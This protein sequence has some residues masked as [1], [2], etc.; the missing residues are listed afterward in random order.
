MMSRD[1]MASNNATVTTPSRPKSSAPSVSPSVRSKTPTARKTNAGGTSTLR[2]PHGGSGASRP[3]SS[4]STTSDA[5]TTF[6]S[7][8]SEVRLSVAGG[9]TGRRTSTTSTMS[10]SSNRTQG[11][12]TGKTMISR[13]RVPST[14]SVASTTATAKTKRPP[15][16]AASTTGSASGPSTPDV[17]TLA[18]GVAKRSPSMAS[19]KS[20]AST[21]ASVVVTPSPPPP[22]KKLGPIRKVGEAKR[23][24]SL[25]GK[26]NG[27]PS[28]PASA[29]ST[30]KGKNKAEAAIMEEDD[31]PPGKVSSESG[32]TVRSVKRKESSDTIKMVVDKLEPTQY[33]Q[34][35]QR[36]HQPRHYQQQKQQPAAIFVDGLND[37]PPRG[38]TLEIGIPC[39]ISSKRKRFRAFARY[40]G[41]V[42]G[43]LGPWVGVEVPF[44]ESWVGDKLEGRQ[45]HDGTWGGVRYFDIGA[46]SS[47]WDD[48]DN[49][50]AVRR[51]KL[52]IMNGSMKGLKREGDQ[53][54]VD[55]A[56]RIR[57][58]SPSTSDVS[59]SESRGLFVRPQQV[60]YVVDAVGTDL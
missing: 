46:A 39:I 48:G 33:Q 20:T 59:N 5:S 60:L 16:V 9:G 49:D 38:A 25:A 31:I 41:E 7:T 29:A 21:T 26:S 11:P 2:P 15:S 30:I 43:E 56:K 18:P 28:S 45:W 24:L 40:I 14:S 42:E 12:S 27:Q 22:P 8:T 58:A 32:S 13:P 54:H 53:L 36:Q 44:G 4:L 17:E 50:R 47:E 6:K 19:V 1:S 55:R 23:P 34:H 57:S 52:D 51:R 37:I 10:N 35:Q 3:T